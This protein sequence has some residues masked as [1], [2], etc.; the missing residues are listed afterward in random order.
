MSTWKVQRNDWVARAIVKGIKHYIVRVRL[1]IV[2]R[3]K[4]YE[5][6]DLQPGSAPGPRGAKADEVG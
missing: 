2:C 4:G 6:V 3:M 5:Q 1:S